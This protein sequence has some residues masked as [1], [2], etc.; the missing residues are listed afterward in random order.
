MNQ[1]YTDTWEELYQEM[2]LENILT[3]SQS[4]AKLVYIY[5]IKFENIIFDVLH[6][7]IFSQKGPSDNDQHGFMKSLRI[8]GTYAGLG[9]VFK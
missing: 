4:S 9:T 5:R 3:K 2:N 8:A 7:V 6:G 1:Q